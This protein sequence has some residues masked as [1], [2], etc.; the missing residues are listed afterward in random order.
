MAYMA[1]LIIGVLNGLAWFCLYRWGYHS[2]SEDGFDEAVKLFEA[3][4]RK[5]KYKAEIQEA[6]NEQRVDRRSVENP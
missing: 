3:E 4:I 1:V 2:G 5:A 6:L